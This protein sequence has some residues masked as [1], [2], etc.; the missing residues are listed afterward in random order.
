[1]TNKLGFYYCVFESNPSRDKVRAWLD[2]DDQYVYFSRDQML[3]FV[4]QITND[5]HTSLYAKMYTALNE[6]SF[7][8]WDVAADTISRLSA[9]TEIK[10]L[11]KDINDLPNSVV[12]EETQETEQSE[13]YWK[14]DVSLDEKLPK[15]SIWKHEKT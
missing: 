6:Y 8:I 13:V 1:M 12:D 2:G 15:I 14:R 5:R 9:N 11:R 10:S 4:K 7:H 3:S